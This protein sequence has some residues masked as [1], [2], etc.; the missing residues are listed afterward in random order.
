MNFEHVSIELLP[1]FGRETL[2]P[3]KCFV[4]AN[5]PAFHRRILPVVSGS[6]R[7]SKP[8]KMARMPETMTKSEVQAVPDA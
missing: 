6:E 7:A 4:T 3:S 8:P 2:L 5:A 1:M